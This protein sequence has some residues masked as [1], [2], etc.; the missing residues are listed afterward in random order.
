MTDRLDRRPDRA[1]PPRPVNEPAAG[2]D[3]PSRRAERFDDA[4]RRWAA[5]PPATPAAE[6]ARRLNARL[7]DAPAPRRAAAGRLRRLA[8]AAA[9]VLIVGLGITLGVLG[10]DGPDG[11]GGPRASDAPAAAPA[12]DDPRTVPVP[13]DVLVIDLDDETT[14]YMN[15]ARSL[16]WNGSG[17]PGQGDRS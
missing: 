17:E 12:A 3:S 9:A 8:V 5:R 7:A 4:L 15:L 1:R 14:L 2:E 11:P 13:D 10:P 16:P 6:A